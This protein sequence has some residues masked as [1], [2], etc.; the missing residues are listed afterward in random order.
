MGTIHPT[1]GNALQAVR[2]HVQAG[3]HDREMPQLSCKKEKIQD[4]SMKGAGSH[5]LD[6]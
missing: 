1:P 5:L 4:K 2:V 3:I 6:L